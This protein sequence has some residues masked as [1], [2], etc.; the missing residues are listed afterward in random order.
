[1]LM[2]KTYA[3]A[4]SV[5]A[6]VAPRARTEGV[7]VREFA[8]AARRAGIRLRRSRTRLTSKAVVTVL[9]SGRRAKENPG[10]H[11]VVIDNG[12][13]YCPKEGVSL[14]LTDYLKKW[15]GRT[16]TFLGVIGS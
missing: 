14:G 12:Y 3:Q 11:L 9:W 16:G 15:H 7:Y 1:M 5:M 2:G 8:T 10:G 6:S 4:A 13:V